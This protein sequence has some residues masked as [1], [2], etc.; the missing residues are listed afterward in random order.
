MAVCLDIAL[1]IDFQCDIH[2]LDDQNAL[3]MP[4]MQ[5]TSQLMCNMTALRLIEG[6]YH[7]PF[8]HYV[9]YAFIGYI[10]ALRSQCSR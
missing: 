7:T 6:V 4:D 5:G 9:P 10:C 2:V 8:L 3:C 1:A